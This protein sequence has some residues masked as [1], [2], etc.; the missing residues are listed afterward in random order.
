MSATTRTTTVTAELLERCTNH[1]LDVVLATVHDDL[2]RSAIAQRIK[3]GEVSV[4][5]KAVTKPKQEVFEGDVVAV[6]LKPPAPLEVTPHPV[7]FEV[8]AEE[9]DFLIINKPAGLTVHHSATKPEEITLVHGLLHRYPEFLDF[10]SHERPGIVHRLDKRTSGLLLVARN[11]TAQTALSQLFKDRTI[12]KTYYAIVKGHMEQSGTIDFPVGRHPIH[13]NRMSA[14]PGCIAPREARTDYEVIE[15]FEVDSFIK[16]DLH[17]GRTHQI[18]VHCAALKHGLLGDE[19]YGK[20]T[21]L[22]T[23]QAL[24]AGHLSFTYKGKD[25]AFEAP[26]PGDMKHTLHEL[27]RGILS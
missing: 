11:A 26:L 24:H 8:I 5:S 23:R 19:T 1:R 16:L 20:C 13:R 25:Y 22:I 18:R 15:H 3:E 17:T 7:D 21:Q 2:S 4:N 12:K 10:E 14:R 6:T 9:P 27:R